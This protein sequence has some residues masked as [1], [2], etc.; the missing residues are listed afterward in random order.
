MARCLRNRKIIIHLLIQAI[1]K[2]DVTFQ[3]HTFEA[4][5]SPSK[6]LFHLKKEQKIETKQEFEEFIQHLKHQ[7][8]IR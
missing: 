8:T 7:H 5:K 4:C 3:L 6:S 1:Y 2:P